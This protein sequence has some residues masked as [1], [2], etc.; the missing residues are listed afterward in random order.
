MSRREPKGP[1]PPLDDEALRELGLRYVGR[2]ATTRAK[3]SRY[4]NRKL[5]E[6]GWAGER[7]PQVDAL[8]EKFAALGFIDDQGFAEGRARS[9]GRRGYGPNRVRQDLFAAGI[10][11]GDGVNAVE[12]AE[13]SAFE[14]ADAFARKKRI[15]PY[16][17][18]PID[19]DRRRKML[20]AMLRAGHD[21]AMA[22]R[23]VEAA[24][25]EPPERF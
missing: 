17:D 19:D 21:F 18:R 9:L 1:R 2:Y 25:G 16:A 4:L 23:F 12:L 22:R 6:R 13:T 11:A 24:P 14:A 10:N 20:A 8:A 15:G 7:A 3:F 5:H